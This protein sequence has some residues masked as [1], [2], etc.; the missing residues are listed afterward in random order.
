MPRY[1]VD[2]R[3]QWWNPDIDP[4]GVYESVYSA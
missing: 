4:V 3:L 1:N 2:R